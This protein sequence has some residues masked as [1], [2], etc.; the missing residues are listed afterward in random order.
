[1]EKILADKNT[2]IPAGQWL[3]IE[4]Q[5]E[6]QEIEVNFQNDLLEFNADLGRNIPLSN[7]G[8]QVPANG[9]IDFLQF[10]FTGEAKTPRVSIVNCPD[11]KQGMV[12]NDLLKGSALPHQAG[13]GSARSEYGTVLPLLYIPKK[14][15]EGGNRPSYRS[16]ASWDRGSA[17]M[18]IHE[19]M[20]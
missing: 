11:Y 19:M 6:E 8:F 9:S 3:E 1:M 15:K 16:I 4:V 12:T 5:V 17:A 14:N 18:Y 13:A 2:T 10:S 7:L 20:V